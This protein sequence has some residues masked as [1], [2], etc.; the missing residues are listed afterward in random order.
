MP[1][2][3]PRRRRR[4]RSPALVVVAAVL[5]AACGG[6]DG[7]GGGSNAPGGE[8][9]AVGCGA[10]S[11]PGDVGGD[12]GGAAIEDADPSAVLRWGAMRAESMDPIR[13]A[14]V[15]YVQLHAVFDTLL[16]ISPE[17]G[18]LM[19]RLASEWEADEESV[20]LHLR[21]DVTFQDG[22]PLDAE[23]VAFNLDRAMNDPDS[24]ITGM[25]E[26]I[27]SVEVVDGSTVELQLAEP[28]PL[29]VLQLLADRPGMMASPEAVRD[30]GGSTAF[31]E[32]PVGAGMYQVE[33]EWFPRE[34]MS[35]RA[36]DGYW[37]TDAQALGGIDFTEVEPDA[38]VNALLSGSV[39]VASVGG[40]DVSA[41]ED[42]PDV[43]LSV[44]P[45]TIGRGL[46]VNP[47]L[48]P[49]DDVRVRQAIAHAINRDAM[50]EALTN[51][52]GEPRCQLFAANSPAY[53]EELD[54]LYPYDPARASEL[55]E[56]AGHA[57]GLEF[58]AIIGSG[59]TAY[60]QFGELLQAQLAEVGIEMDLEL[61]DRSQ[62][63]PMLY[64]EDAAPAAPIGGG[65]DAALTDVFI[66]NYLLE[67]GSFNAG[68]VELPEVRDLVE[69]A[70]AQPD[71]ASAR[72][73]YQELNRAV[74]ED[75]FQIIPVYADAAITGHQTNVGG[76]HPGL[77][78]ID[79]SPELLRGVFVVE[80]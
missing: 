39:D 41:L 28:T 20:V 11:S 49:F 40:T 5:A 2:A 76:L 66:R 73:L 19:P 3:P 18:E 25:L 38:K 52:Y 47:T 29:A 71:I 43:A 37:D 61:V 78:D 23:A 13:E 17:D 69:E 77:L 48:E 26:A 32:A 51:G 9:D 24:N 14:G 44:G 27:E 33:G 75:L 70:G 30:A 58:K 72:P 53:D 42:E 63:L 67:D 12:E 22:T 1:V 31:S 50:V 21:D 10:A 79:P 65:A 45:A 36:W 15:D 80:D 56:E 4:W 59:A 64:E 57:D 54:G 68:D 46:T 74:A 60:I 6:G 34:S 16:S 62:T 55:L 35:V 7:G 8:E